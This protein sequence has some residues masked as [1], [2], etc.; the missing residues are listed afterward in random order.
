MSLPWESGVPADGSFMEEVSGANGVSNMG[1]RSVYSFRLRCHLSFITAS[2][3][4][5]F[6][7]VSLCVCV[8]AMFVVSLVLLGVR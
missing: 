3:R 4:T 8:F 7:C 6:L 1:W 5:V 2:E